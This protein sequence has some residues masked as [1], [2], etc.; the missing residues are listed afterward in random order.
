MTNEGRRKVLFITPGY[1][2]DDRTGGGQRTRLIFSALN[3]AYDVDV[4]VVGVRVTKICAE[5][6]AEA[7]SIRCAYNAQPGET[8]PYSMIRQFQPR[9]VDKVATVL[10]HKKR[11]YTADHQMCE[12][13]RCVDFNSY[14]L[15]VGRYLRST[16]RTG[17][18]EFPVSPPVIIDVDD[19]DDQIVESRINAPGQSAWMKV[20]L[21]QHLAA[22]RRIMDELLPLGSHL[23]VASDADADVLAHPSVSV[24]QNI[25]FFT[26][27]N[28]VQG[29]TVEVRSNKT[30]LFVGSAGHMPNM[31]GITNFILHCWPAIIKNHPTAQLRIV[32]S[33]EWDKL[34]PMKTRLPGV[35]VVGELD[36]LT[37]EYQ[38]AS[39]CIS[40]VERGGGT[41]IKVLEALAFER[42]IV[43]ALNSAYGLPSEMLNGPVSMAS[44][45]AQMVELCNELLSGPETARVNALKGR[46][47]IEEKFSRQQ[48][49]RIVT[50]D[51]ERIIRDHKIKS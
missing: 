20:L 13:L 1:A 27:S 50:E 26:P 32:G 49:S 43:S 48:F 36:D 23:W 35:E 24:L 45:G 42:V 14:D 6:F 46:R 17:V 37:P 15:I 51:C 8:K 10:M 41:K 18:L 25:P 9:L 22:I 4:L 28:E 3:S 39:F 38:R 33:G 40:P 2:C 31:E 21:K 47:I 11:L 12:S 44:D 5:A 16:A 30:I 29:N 34:L 19:R 7:N